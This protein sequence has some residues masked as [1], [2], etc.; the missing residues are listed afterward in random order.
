MLSIITIAHEDFDA[1]RSTVASA[2][3]QTHPEIEHV[4]IDGGST[5]GTGDWI[6]DNTDIDIGISEPDDGRYDAMNKGIDHATGEYVLFLNAGDVFASDD[7]IASVLGREAVLKRQPPIVSG[8]VELALNGDP[9]GL[10]RPWTRG[11]EGPGLPHPAT[12]IDRE[13]HEVYRYDNQFAYC[14]DYDLWARLKRD[15]HFD[16]T[17][18][19][20]VIAV[21]DVGGASNDP[22]TAFER[23]LERVF[24]DYRHGGGFGPRRALGLL[25]VPLIRGALQRML[26]HRRFVK[27]LRYRKLV[28]HR[29]RSAGSDGETDG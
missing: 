28:G 6:E 19:D 13:L 25:T 15:G 2:A 26:G 17:Y 21:F 29:L 24:V 23:Y 18:V 20:D 14:G 9:L 5:D 12:M 22:G 11:A 10:T 27:L 3:N 4:V 7:A 16:V 1:L 8:R